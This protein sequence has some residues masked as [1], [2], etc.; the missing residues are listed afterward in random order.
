MAVHCLYQDFFRFLE[1]LGAGGDSWEAYRE[2]YLQPHQDFFE[3]YWQTFPLVDGETLRDRVAQIRRGHYSAL[4]HLL[5]Q[6]EP[7]TIVEQD[8]LRCQKVL[9]RFPEPDV[10]LLV[11]FF[12][13]DGFIV[14][15]G[16]WPAIGIGLERFK[17]FRLLGLI[18]AHEYCHYARRLALGSFSFEPETLGQK[19]LAEGLSAVFSQ[20]IYP[21]RPLTDHLLMSR[22]RLNWCQKN[23]ASLESTARRELDTSRLVPMFFQRGKPGAGIPPRT[24]MYLGYR[25]V[26][27]ALMER[28]EGAFE[29]LLKAP[30]IT[31]V[32]SP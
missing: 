15:V 2:N 32:W 9:P 11:G 5:N 19:L 22:H 13:A 23:E 27:R 16:G 1:S 31:A 7:E 25:L 4:E 29:E 26:E 18:L 3:A 30:D 8:L 20:R 10:Y 17:D 24:G 21:Q 12:S 28:E 6:K 14:V